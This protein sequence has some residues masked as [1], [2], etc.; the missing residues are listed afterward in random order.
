[1]NKYKL[2]SLLCLVVAVV[3]CLAGIALFTICEFGI[4]EGNIRIYNCSCGIDD[5]DRSFYWSLYV[6]LMTEIKLCSPGCARCHNCTEIENTEH[7]TKRSPVKDNYNTADNTTDSA[8]PN[9]P[10]ID[11]VRFLPY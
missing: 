8:Q 1:M 2:I 7:R 11:D 4:S 6:I 5:N 3:M 10:T 9:G